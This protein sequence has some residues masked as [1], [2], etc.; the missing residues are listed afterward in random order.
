MKK[1]SIADIAKELEVSK[2]T[3][4]FVLNKRDKSIS[5]QTRQRILEFVKKVGYKPNSVAKALKEGKTN[6]IGYLVPDISNPFYGNIARK[7]EQQLDDTPYQLIIGSTDESEQKESEIIHSLLDRQIDGLILASCNIKS[8]VVKNMINE[9]FPLVLFDR[10]DSDVLANY[11][12]VNSREKISEA[13]GLWLDKGIKRI[14][15]LSITPDISSLKERIEGFKD[16]L[17]QKRI[18]F[19]EE[20]I[21]TVDKDDIKESCFIQLKALFSEDIEAIFFTNNLVCIETLW[22][23]KKNFPEQIL[24]IKLLSFDNIDFFDLAIPPV[25]SI[26]QPVNEIATSSVKQLLKLIKSP[27]SKTEIKLLEP[28]IIYR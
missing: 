16:T 25:N 5:P 17:T 23:L 18:D 24:K 2:T 27:G 10:M 14:G 12:I 22:H 11:I 26:A 3:V 21:R 13:L 8:V 4:S 20:W 7:I 6:T 19:K 1:Y 9:Q 28:S 15:L